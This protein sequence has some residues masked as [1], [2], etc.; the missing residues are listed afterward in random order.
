MAQLRV[1]DLQGGHLLVTRNKLLMLPMQ[2]SGRRNFRGSQGT[3]VLEIPTRL[4][5]SLE[6]FV[7]PFQLSD[8]GLQ[9][10]DLGGHS[11]SSTANVGFSS[12]A[13]RHFAQHSGCAAIETA[14]AA[15]VALVSAYLQ[16]NVVSV[17]AGYDMTRS[18]TQNPQRIS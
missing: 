7:L 10:F 11:A 4:S 3:N 2:N 13:V 9:P 5:L 8:A 18:V 14:S 12:H 17:S 1:F 6:F 15:W 16:E